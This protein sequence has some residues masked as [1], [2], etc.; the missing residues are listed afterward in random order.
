[1][2]NEQKGP[3]IAWLLTDE[4]GNTQLFRERPDYYGGKLVQIV[5]WEV[6]HEQ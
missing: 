3:C 1:M 4:Y 5:Y 2:S 6:A